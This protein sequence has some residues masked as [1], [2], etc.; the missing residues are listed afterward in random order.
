[1]SVD[2]QTPDA[3]AYELAE[4]EREAGLAEALVAMEAKTTP[5]AA[6]FVDCRT[7]GHSW[8][9]IE[10]DRNPKGYGWYMKLQ[11]ER[12]HTVRSDIV[13]HHGDVMTRSYEYPESY[14]D[15]DHWTRSDWR[16]QFLRRLS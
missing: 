5:G 14:K 11:C 9:E 8:M 15:A 4:Q 10:A 1:M 3:I 16:M 7:F 12:C 13:N 2:E 6:K